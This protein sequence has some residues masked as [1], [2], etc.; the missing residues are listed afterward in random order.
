MLRN[1]RYLNR[2]PSR[3][4]TSCP[5]SIG[6]D[7]C[8]HMIPHPEKAAKGG[9]DACFIADN[10]CVLGIA[11]GVGGWAESGVDPAVYA[12]EI[13]K[14]AENIANSCP[15]EPPEAIMHQAYEQTKSIGSSTVRGYDLNQCSSY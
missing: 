10:K 13:M 12:R 5:F 2:L 15:A 7:V 11:D 3:V 1:L 4:I 9:E 14:R 8:F 6:I